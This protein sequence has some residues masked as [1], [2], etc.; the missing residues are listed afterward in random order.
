MTKLMRI[1]SI[2]PMVLALAL[3]P[4]C[5]TTVSGS[6][7]MTYNPSTG[8]F[9]GTATV[10]VTIKKKSLRAGAVAGGAS[11]LEMAL[12]GIGG[13]APTLTSPFM[14]VAVLG[15]RGEQLGAA[16]FEVVQTEAGTYAFRDPE[17][18]DAWLAQ[19]GEAASVVMAFD[20]TGDGNPFQATVYSEGVSLGSDIIG[21]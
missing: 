19:L 15:S 3:L 5:E 1:L 18:V 16:P 14:N 4:A 11:G 7:T 13:A 21:E 17:A 12:A 9:E 20:M 8:K 2:V 6:T 10:T